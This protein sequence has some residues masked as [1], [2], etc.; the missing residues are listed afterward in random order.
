[1]NDAPRSGIQL[2][3]VRS[4][5]ESLPDIIRQVG[6]AGYDGVEFADRFREEPPEG[7]AGALDET[8]IEPI[9]VHADLSAV[10]AA[11]AGENDLIERCHTV[12]CDRIIIPHLPPQYFT[13]QERIRG[14]SFR[15]HRVATELGEHDI[16][17]G[18][19]TV[20]DHLNPVLPDSVGTLVRKTPAPD[21]I[22]YYL[23]RTAERTRQTGLTS[24][25]AE[26]A[27]EVLNACTAPE[28]L[29]FEVEAAEFRAAGYDLAGMSPQFLD[30]TDLIHV[31][32]VKQG[33]F[34]NHVN[35]P[36]G[37]GV[38][39]MERVVDTAIGADVEWLIYENELDE[40]PESKIEAGST[41]L[42]EQLASARQVEPPEEA[43][44]TE[45]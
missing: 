39:D 24:I 19:H 22:S 7:I 44:V 40:E 42:N 25:S 12:G 28:Q 8:G 2:F 32:D 31:R 18:I 13:T 34:G 5:P 30:R 33:W 45:D 6:D 4:H 36:H 29:F 15:L 9:S 43:V 14:L 20:R 1:M 23:V 37:D 26:P 41:L 16:D 17:L 27:L 38:L 3:S 11:T 10:E 21:S 35:V